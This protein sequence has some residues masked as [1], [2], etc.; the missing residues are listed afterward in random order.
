MV[1]EEVATKEKRYQ[2][3]FHKAQHC[4]ILAQKLGVEA[5]YSAPDPQ[6]YLMVAKSFKEE[7]G[8]WNSAAENAPTE[9]H[10]KIALGNRYGAWSNHYQSLA[11]HN[12][13]RGAF[14]KAT[15]FYGKAI[16]YREKAIE[17]VPWEE[18]KEAKLKGSWIDLKYE[19]IEAKNLASAILKPSIREVERRIERRFG[20]PVGL[21]F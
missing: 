18:T 14:E 13:H 2:V 6:M 7:V 16:E 11:A 8:Y 20:L 19:L 9:T 10:Q 17:T 4:H 1:K 5:R 21:G 15:E 12:Y 3:Y